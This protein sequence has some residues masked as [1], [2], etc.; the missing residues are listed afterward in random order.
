M[1]RRERAHAWPPGADEDAAREDAARMVTVA[2]GNVR[3]RPPVYNAKEPKE[4]C[5]Y[6]RSYAV[7]SNLL[8]RTA[9]AF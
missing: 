9:Y 2:R 5:V 1:R 3:R 7:R 8:P 4:L 6:L